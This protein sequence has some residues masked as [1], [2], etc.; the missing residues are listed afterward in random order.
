[1]LLAKPTAHSLS[2]KIGVGG[3]GCLMFLSVRRTSQARVQFVCTVQYPASVAEATMTGIR[4][5]KVITDYRMIKG[6]R[7]ITFS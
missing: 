1:M 7:V 2:V 6:S 3:W 5:G 4:V